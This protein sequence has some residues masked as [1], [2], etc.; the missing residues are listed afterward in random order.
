[1]HSDIA[2]IEKAL[3]A[4][5]PNVLRLAV[6]QATGDESLARMRVTS[7]RLGASPF[8]AKTLAR[9]DRDL[10]VERAKRHLTGG[11]PP[12]RAGAS[13]EIAEL[14]ALFEGETPSHNELLLAVDELGFDE[15]PRAANWTRK[16]PKDAVS[17]YRVA[18]IGAGVSGLAAA[19]QLARLG[20]P[21]DIFERQKDLGGVWETNR[22]PEARVDLCS[23]VY[24]FKFEKNY[25]WPEY[26]A[27]QAVNKEYLRHIALKYGIVEKIKLGCEVI[28]AAW[29]DKAA[30]WN[31]DVRSADGAV[32][33]I[34]PHFVISAS[35]LFSTPNIPDIPGLDSFQGRIFHTTAWPAD[36][37]TEG[38]RAALIGN[39]STGVQLMNWLARATDKL[40]VFQRTPQWLI[41]ARNYGA[42]IANE[43]Q[44]LF[45]NVPYYWNWYCYAQY[46]FLQQYQSFEEHDPEWQENGGRISKANDDLREFLT[47]YIRENLAGRPDLISKSIPSYAPFARRMVV[48]N[49]W[50]EALMRENVELITDGIDRVTPT[51]IATRGGDRRDVDFIVLGAGFAVERYFSPVDYVGRDGAQLNDLWSKDGP[52]SYLGVAMPRFPNL[53][54][55]YGPNSQPRTGG[56][57]AWAEMWA[58]YT[59]QLIIRTIEAGASSIEC[60]RDAYDSYN[61]RLDAQMRRLIWASEGAGGYHVRAFGR[62]VMHSPWLT[63]DYAAMLKEPD[64]NAFNLR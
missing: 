48:D 17:R 18:I 37:Q 41:P 16:P 27:R 40:F 10:V 36:L 60:A 31:V 2:A 30:R 38:K 26:F 53:F 13:I 9:G 15:F 5:D 59:A 57:H 55:L 54:T 58:K 52:R 12:L 43:V 64:V 6:Y 35:G 29:D 33:R 39:G 20:V 4:A 45:D 50:Y 42:P 24:Q 62:S 3:A 56:F 25:P 23:H 14:I 32:S 22:Y 47:N 34:A 63:Q 61:S 44:W 1:M 46:S 19:V 49:G 28:A 51:A 21:Y 7:R 8:L 11:A